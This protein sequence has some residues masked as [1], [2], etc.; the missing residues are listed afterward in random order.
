MINSGSFRIE[1]V[2]KVATFE[3]KAHPLGPALVAVCRAG[4]ARQAAFLID[5]GVPVDALNEQELGPLQHAAD[6]DQGTVVRL[7]IDRGADIDRVC[8][9]HG[10][11]LH[12]AASMG[13]IEALGVL[14]DQGADVNVRD[15]RQQT[16]LHMAAWSSSI[17]QDMLVRTLIVA[18]A[19]MTSQNVDGDSPLHAAAMG[20][21][22]SLTAL[23]ACGANLEACNHQG[24]TPLQIALKMN[25]DINALTLIAHG[26]NAHVLDRHDHNKFFGLPEIHAAA[27]LGLTH[28]VIELLNGGCSLDVRWCPDPISDPLS[29]S[30]TPVEEAQAAGQ[31][32]V[33]AAIAA[34]QAHRA[35]ESVLSA[36]TQRPIDASAG[37]SKRLKAPCKPI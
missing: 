7:L 10:T 27:R 13:C 34:W 23:I 15:H 9:G 17:H 37:T 29:R 6:C 31:D 24:R 8:G 1:G 33:V 14:I 4:D 20:A 2:Q 11:A 16:P 18:G 12:R 5:S 30:R 21:S 19:S 22:S 25:Q 28:R 32:Q 3:H 35:I 26:A 36:E